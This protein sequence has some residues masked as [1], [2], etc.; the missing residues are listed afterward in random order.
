[1]SDQI[2]LSSIAQVNPRRARHTGAVGLSLVVVTMLG[3]GGVTWHTLSCQS[4]KLARLESGQKMMI[5][6]EELSALHT[7]L[8]VLATR[9]GGIE[10]RMNHVAGEVT[11]L[12]AH[13]QEI[14]GIAA[15]LMSLRQDEQALNGR[16]T[17][18]QEQASL[19][20][21]FSHAEAATPTVLHPTVIARQEAKSVTLTPKPRGSITHAVPFV[22][23]G[24][25]LRGAD[26]LAAVAPRGFE[27][28]SQVQ[29]VGPGESF[30][31]WLLVEAGQQQAQFRSGNRRL[32]LNS[33][34]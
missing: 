9:T 33:E 11:S 28:L 7:S 26:V 5:S 12:K 17:H 24:T 34:H 16:V 13:P 8:S 23:T 10:T 20:S 27:N 22:L 3:V 1:M 25:E 30:M 18:L 29:L 4:Q 6:R 19:V 2:S 15:Q 31:G 32:T 21:D 14:P